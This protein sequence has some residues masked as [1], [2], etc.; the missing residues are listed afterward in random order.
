MCDD[1]FFIDE[2]GGAKGADGGF[3]AHFL[4]SPSPKCLQKRRIRVRYDVKVEA[5]LLDEFL[6]RGG[7]IF[8]YTENGVALGSQ[9]LLVVA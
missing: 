8:A 9:C 3:A 5:L 6:V 7:G 1:A 4:F 2:V